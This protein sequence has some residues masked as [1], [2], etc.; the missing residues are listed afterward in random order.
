MYKQG[1]PL[2][3]KKHFANSKKAI[4]LLCEL[5]VLILRRILLISREAVLQGFQLENF[6]WGG[7]GGSIIT[8][9]YVKAKC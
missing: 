7:V 3:R 9:H 1:L 2:I 8:L 4:S 5:S 6:V